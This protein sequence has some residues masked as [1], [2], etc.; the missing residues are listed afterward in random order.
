MKKNILT[1]AML[2]ALFLT[3]CKENAKQESTEITKKEA[4]EKTTDEIVTA[5]ETDKDGKKLEM[6]FN[7]TKNTATLKLN[8]E[9]IEMVLDSTMASGSNYKNE[10]YHYTQWHNLT[11]VEKD[12]KVIFEAGKETKVGE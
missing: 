10:H 2:T 11:T 4:V 1:I 9:T 6:S 8:G 7:N 5:T 12:G 3:S